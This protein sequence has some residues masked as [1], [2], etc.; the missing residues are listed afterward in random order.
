[1][2]RKGF[3]LLAALILLASA[4]ASRPPVPGKAEEGIPGRP[5]PE[6]LP[7]PPSPEIEEREAPKPEAQVPGKEEKEGPSP[8]ES[9]R[10]LYER[11]LSAMLKEGP[12][13]ALK[14]LEGLLSSYPD[15][16]LG[17]RAK[18]EITLYEGQYA[19][20]EAL[21]ARA[22]RLEPE[23]FRS[24]LGLAKAKFFQGKTE[25]AG[26]LLKELSKERPQETEVRLYLGF[27][28]GK[29]E[30]APPFYM[31]TESPFISRGQA[32]ALL[33]IFLLSLRSPEPEPFPVIMTDVREHWALAHIQRAVQ[34]RVLRAFPD[35]TFRPD[36]LLDRATMAGALERYFRLLGMEGQ[37]PQDFPPLPDI[38]PLNVHYPP[39]VFVLRLGLMERLP[40]G[41]FG[42]AGG[43]SGKEALLL[44]E[45]ARF[46]AKLFEE[47]SGRPLV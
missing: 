38:A 11:V 39:A 28:E 8:T 40:D 32:A 17:Y 34:H 25:E 10:R 15:E 9:P 33:D 20:A 23:N 19:E 43:L 18:A 27:I 45:R 3:F 31:I 30:F 29:G 36:A 14:A 1:M 41:H 2:K 42:L 47:A 26:E 5:I 37:P 35:H 44:M 46:L 7:L 4:C 24:R 16:G 22:A 12:G 6:R 21:F 13:N